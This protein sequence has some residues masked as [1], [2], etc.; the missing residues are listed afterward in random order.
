MSSRRND[1]PE[2]PLCWY[3]FKDGRHCCQPADP[4][5]DGLCYSHGTFAQRASRQDN[6]QHILIP[7]ADGRSSLKAR[8]RAL[9]GLYRAIREGRVS[10]E[11]AQILSRIGVLIDQSTRYADQSSFTS[12][13]S[14]AWTRLRQAVDAL[15]S[16]RDK[17]KP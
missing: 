11:R 17:R 16:F 15:D 3:I 2:S 7:L 6:L 8:N 5:Y 4:K 14:P 13:E 12:T 1:N 9:R 10:P